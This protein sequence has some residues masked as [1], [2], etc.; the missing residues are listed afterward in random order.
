VPILL[1]VLLLVV[2]E[3]P[4]LEYLY[5]FLLEMLLPEYLYTDLLVDFETP[6]ELV[7][8]LY[9]VPKKPLFL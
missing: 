8:N 6:A 4:G 2:L 7:D 3:I 1:L 9:L 5:N